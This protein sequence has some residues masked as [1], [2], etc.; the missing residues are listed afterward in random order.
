M[1]LTAWAGIGPNKLKAKIASDWNKPN[2]PL[3]LQPQ[4]VPAHR[5]DL[6]VR[7]VWGAGR[8][9]VAAVLDT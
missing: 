4:E 3:E 8:V 7:R 6:P 1:E 5:R 9:E 2:G